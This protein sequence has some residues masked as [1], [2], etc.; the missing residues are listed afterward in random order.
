M[1]NQL[2]LKQ[3]LE[4]LQREIQKETGE[5]HARQASVTA[6][7]AEKIKLENEKKIDLVEKNKLEAEL[8][9]LVNK[10]NQTNKRI[11]DVNKEKPKLEEEIRRKLA[12]LNEKNRDLQKNQDA[13][14]SALVKSK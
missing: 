9:K 14:R 13:L 7:G 5:L 10:I 1:A 3:A 4:Q 2:D 8:L 12:D 6:L 11:L